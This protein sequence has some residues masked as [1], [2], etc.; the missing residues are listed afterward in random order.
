[1]SLR[2]IPLPNLPTK[3]PAR[4]EYFGM[5]RTSRETD[6]IVCFTMLKQPKDTSSHRNKCWRSTRN[7]RVKP[8]SPLAYCAPPYFGLA[9]CVP[10]FLASRTAYRLTTKTT[11]FWR[12]HLHNEDKMTVCC[13]HM[14][15]HSC[16][17]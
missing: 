3:P 9:Y 10:P 11:I 13:M 12:F 17:R 15:N 5:S 8:P 7:L 16:K 2:A 1:M 6:Q 4:T 14:Y